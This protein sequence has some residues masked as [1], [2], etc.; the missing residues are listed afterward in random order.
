MQ[1]SPYAPIQF[2]RAWPMLAA[3]ADLKVI[4][5]HDARHTHA[6]IMLKQGVHP[7]IVQERLEHANIAITLDTYS[8]VSPG[9]Q[10]A[11]AK[12]FDEA[13]GNNYNKRS[14]AIDK[15]G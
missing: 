1:C 2:T 15:F 7:R 12:S 10:T 3:H 6:P 5:L 8:H 11:A 13:L 4:R 9:L 14:E